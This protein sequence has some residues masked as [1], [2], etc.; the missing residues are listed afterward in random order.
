MTKEAIE[1][2][3]TASLTL[4]LGLAALD[5][6]LYIWFGTAVLTVVA[7]ALSL[8]LFVRYRLIFDLVKLLETS[9]LF[10]DI[11]LINMYGF[12]VASPLATL[13]AIIHVSLNKKY[14]LDKLKIDL[15]KVLASKNKDVENDKK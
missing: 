5:L 13:F 15:D 4:M 1:R 6:A 9:A 14:H 3:L 7:H 11:Y 12:A 8:W 10:F 2:A